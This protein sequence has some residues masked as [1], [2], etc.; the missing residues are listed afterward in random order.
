MRI[1][2]FMDALNYLCT[3]CSNSISPAKVSKFLTSLTKAVTSR[4]NV[5]VL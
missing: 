5:V 4:D 2:A 3:F 1:D